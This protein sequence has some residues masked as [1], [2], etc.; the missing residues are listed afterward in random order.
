MAHGGAS[1]SNRLPDFDTSVPACVIVLQCGAE[2][3][4][5][6]QENNIAVFLQSTG[7]SKC[8]GMLSWLKLVPRK[9][10]NTW[11]SECEPDSQSRQSAQD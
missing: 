5:K 7:S 11:I 2:S 4:I 8:F 10:E 1:L 6:R 9:L 3:L